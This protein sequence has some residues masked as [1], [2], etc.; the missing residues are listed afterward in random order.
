MGTCRIAELG[1]VWN[2]HI[3][4]IYVANPSAHAAVIREYGMVPIGV[5]SDRE[6]KNAA[7][8]AMI[9]DVLRELYRGAADAFCIVSADQDYTRLIQAIREE[10]KPVFV[11]GPP[12]TAISLKAACTS[13][14]ELFSNTAF[15][16]GV[17]SP[18]PQKLGAVKDR[19]QL[20][21]ALKEEV[22]HLELKVRNATLS[23]LSMAYRTRD[24]DFSPR[25]Y[26]A[27]NLTSLL[28]KLGAFD[29]H[30]LQTRLGNIG[31]YQVTVRNGL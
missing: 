13:F 22:H 16:R 27:R 7:D 29:L 6:S 20:I 10:A 8:H 4:R 21:S 24:R 19:H 15:E 5:L 28:R 31:D 18:V 30:P 3:R 23:S 11:F 26:R 12:H 17:T 1:E 9:V 14:F 2:P 25:L